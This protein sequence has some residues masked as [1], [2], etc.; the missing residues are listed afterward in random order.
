MYEQIHTNGATFT[1]AR[2]YELKRPEGT[3]WIFEKMAA[4]IVNSECETF[5]IEEFELQ[6]YAEERLQQAIKEGV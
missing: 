6:Y 5:G 1:F 4:D 3:V 2:V